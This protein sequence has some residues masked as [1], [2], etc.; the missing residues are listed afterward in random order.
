VGCPPVKARGACKICLQAR[1]PRAGHQAARQQRRQN[2]EARVVAGTI[3]PTKAARCSTKSSAPSRR[4]SDNG[5]RR[6]KRLDYNLEG[7]TRTLYRLPKLA[8]APKSG[9][10]KVNGIATR[11]PGWASR[12]HQQRRAGKWPQDHAAQFAGKRVVIIPDADKPARN[13]PNKWR[14]RFT[15]L[16]RVSACAFCPKA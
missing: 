15:A 6:Q 8:A 16:P 4:D 9:L 13:T 10:Q 5:A 2:Y 1:G 7:V 14:V 3:T 11:W 12:N